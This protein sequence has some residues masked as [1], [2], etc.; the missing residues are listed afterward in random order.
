MALGTTGEPL[1]PSAIRGFLNSAR[2]RWKD[3][4]RVPVPDLGVEF[5][6]I[7]YVVF[8]HEDIYEPLNVCAIIQNTLPKSLELHIHPSENLADGGSLHLHFRLTARDRPKRRW[9]LDSN[10]AHR[11]SPSITSGSS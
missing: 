10:I 8:I 9:N 7:P 5:F 4:N 6:L 1:V 2:N 3:R 11:E